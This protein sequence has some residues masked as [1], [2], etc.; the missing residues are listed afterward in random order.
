MYN[1]KYGKR[2]S[3]LLVG[4]YRHIGTEFFTVDNALNQ[5]QKLA[6]KLFGLEQ[7]KENFEKLHDDLITMLDDES[8]N[9]DLMYVKCLYGEKFQNPTPISNI[10]AFL[11]NTPTSDLITDDIGLAMTEVKNDYMGGNSIFYLKSIGIEK[12]SSLYSLDFLKKTFEY[13]SEEDE[14]MKIL[15]TID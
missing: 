12:D 3:E 7:S 9:D 2:K 10:E 13:L 5:D 11:Q 15:Y 14:L 6:L 8:M 1:F 4:Y